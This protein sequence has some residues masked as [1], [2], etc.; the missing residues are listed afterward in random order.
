MPEATASGS[1][2]SGG[3]CDRSSSQAKEAQER[4]ALLRDVVADGA[5]QHGIARLERVQH[6]ALRD[7]LQARPASPRSDL[8]QRSQ[9][10][11]QYDADHGSVCT[12]TESTAGRSRTIGCPAVAGV[13]R[14]IDL[15]AGGAEID[16]ALVE[17]V[18]RHGVAQHVHVAVALAAG[19]WSAAPTRCRRCGCDRRAACLPGES[20]R[21]RS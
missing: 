16:A 12:S 10:R 11:R 5:A 4:P 18:D 21:R 9:M 17:R 14:G 8:G 13:R 1:G 7:R 6:R 20:A 3:S 19:L 2:A 15:P